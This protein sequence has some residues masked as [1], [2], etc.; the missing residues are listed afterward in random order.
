MTLDE[1]LELV[2][3]LSN[4]YWVRWWAHYN[5]P[6]NDPY[7]IGLSLMKYDGNPVNPDEFAA[8]DIGVEPQVIEFEAYTCYLFERFNED[9]S[10]YK[11][12]V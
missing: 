6:S 10:P 8:I 7:K 1:L 3:M 5:Y 12:S 9:G 2:R 4:K 11:S